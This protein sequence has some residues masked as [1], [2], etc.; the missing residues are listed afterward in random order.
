MRC[1]FCGS[2]NIP[3]DDICESCGSELAGLDLPEASRG[4]SGRL[5]SDRVGDLALQDPVTVAPDD[6]VATAVERMRRHR[7]GC[8]LVVRDGELVGL[9]NERHLLTGV[10]RPGHNPRS[11]LVA[12]VMT[13]DLVKLD[14]EDP[15]AH[16]VHCMVSRGFRH[17]PVV[18]GGR[19]IGFLSV[20]TILGYLHRDVI[21]G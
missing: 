20:R 7:A 19:L 6:S 15:P 17:L 8:V 21:A 1:P 9:F 18:E 3:G 2:R 5:L 14:P 11:V 4:F 16:A 10:V 12:D 13:T